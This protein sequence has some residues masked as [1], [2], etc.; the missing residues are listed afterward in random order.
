[1]TTRRIDVSGEDRLSVLDDPCPV[2]VRP[3]MTRL[4]RDIGVARASSLETMLVAARC[5]E[6]RAEADRVLEAML[7]AALSEG[8]GRVAER[9]D[10]RAAERGARPLHG[11]A[12]RHAVRAQVEADPAREPWPDYWF[13]PCDAGEA[14]ALRRMWG[15][16]LYMGVID[17]I[18]EVLGDIK[19]RALRGDT[20]PPRHFGW[21]VTPDFR[22]VADHA[23][24]DRDR[25]QDLAD[26]LIGLARAR[27][28]EELNRIRKTLMGATAKEIG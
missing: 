26:H 1:M 27:D 28:V 24:L 3:A 18:A 23:G 22:E 5:D 11:D 20:E 10:V 14:A 12:L 4:A 6:M 2:P 17:S 8:A 19:R 21:I 25:A 16:A 15:R 9:K 7:V 13:A